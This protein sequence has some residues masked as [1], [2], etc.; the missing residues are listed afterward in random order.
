MSAEPGVAAGRGRPPRTSRAEVGRVALRLFAARGFEQTTVEDIADALG[1]GRRT[2][3]RYYASK[4]DIVWGDFDL[5][6]ERLAVD[7]AGQPPGAPVIDSVARAAVSS[8]RYTPAEMGELRV[9]MTLIT[10]VPALQ[11]H[12]MLRYADWRAVVARYVARRRG[13]SP[14]DLIPQT[15]AFAA[16]GVSMAAFSAWVAGGTE[17]EVALNDAYAGLAAG[18]P[19]R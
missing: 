3:F 1:V 4:N 10:S 13:D 14:Q 2:V 5:V 18:F 6:L 11:A 9:R 19:D 17:L 8:N 15:I 16:L 7:L 12:S